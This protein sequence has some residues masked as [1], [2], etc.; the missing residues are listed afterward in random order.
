MNNIYKNISIKNIA[1]LLPMFALLTSCS[2]GTELEPDR[3][4]TVTNPE[5][6]ETPVI[7]NISTPSGGEIVYSRAEDSDYGIQLE[8]EMEIQTL[9]VYDFPVSV[10]KDTF[11]EEILP[12]AKSHILRPDQSDGVYLQPDT[13]TVSQGTLTANMFVDASVYAQ[14]IFV[15]VANESRDYLESKVK[16]GETTLNQLLSMESGKVLTEGASSSVL[17]Q[18]GMTMTGRSNEITFVSGETANITVDLERIAARIDVKNDVKETGNFRILEV[19]ARNCSP[20]GWLFS[21]NY[22]GSDNEQ[23]LSA[24]KAV[25]VAMTETADTELPVLAGGQ[26]CP[27]V[28]YL[29]ARTKNGDADA[30]SDAKEISL[31]VQYAISGIERTVFVNRTTD[32]NPITI[33]RNHRYTLVVGSDNVASAPAMVVCRLVKEE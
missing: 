21:K 27:G 32:N 9:A 4:G 14:H 20:R 2:S 12:L 31:E 17:T 25:S 1:T 11:A 26:S 19:T 16:E 33:E 6:G 28:F 15:V 5:L 29:H 23:V 18:G 10:D 13:Y 8:P 30:G 24:D 22:S 3:P 7:L